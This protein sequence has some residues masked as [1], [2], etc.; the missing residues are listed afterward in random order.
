MPLEFRAVVNLGCLAGV[1]RSK[2]QQLKGQDVDT[3]EL[4]WL[5]FKTMASYQYL[6]PN[7]YKYIYLY[8]HKTGNKAMF[9]LI[10][11][12]Q[13][14]GTIFVLDTVFFQKE[15][16]STFQKLFRVNLDHNFGSIEL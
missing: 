16:H 8:H 10:I 1:E 14:K 4:S 13:K 7:S 15:T 11:P 9:G 6:E 2:A 3:F 12:S 5:Q